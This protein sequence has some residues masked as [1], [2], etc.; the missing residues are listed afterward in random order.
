[1]KRVDQEDLDKVLKELKGKLI[2][3]EGKNDKKALEGLGVRNV[4]AINGRPLYKIVQYTIKNSK[5]IIILTDFDKQ[6]KKIHSKLRMLMNRQNVNPNSRIRH[7]VRSLGRS[8]IEDLGNLV[9][10][11]LHEK[12]VDSYGQISANIDKVYNKSKDKSKRNNRKTRRNRS[13]I[14]TN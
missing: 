6:G 9:S 10:V 14:R 12:E 5:E 2:I 1:M 11:S 7:M 3:V 13:G 8:R 4:I